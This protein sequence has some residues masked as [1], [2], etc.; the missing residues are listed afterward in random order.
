LDRERLTQSGKGLR[1]IGELEW[2]YINFGV[3][4]MKAFFLI[5]LFLFAPVSIVP[6]QSQKASEEFIRGIW[7]IDGG[8]ENNTPRWWLEWTFEEGKFSQTGYPVVNQKGSYRIVKVKDGK[9]TLELFDQQ[10]DFGSKNSKID[11]VLDLKKDL[12]TIKDKGPFKRVILKKS[13][14]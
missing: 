5:L 2:G 11:V 12:L 4:T 6:A 3:S 13:S 14:Y 10:G 8:G 7:H 1:D 9:L